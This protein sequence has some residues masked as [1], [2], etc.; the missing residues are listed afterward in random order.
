[1]EEKFYLDDFELSLKEH[2]DQFKM[3]PTKRVWH[4]IYNDLHPG[5]RWPS[6]MI[7]LL[8][9][10]STVFVGYINSHT[11]RKSADQ[12]LKAPV[13]RQGNMVKP[14]LNSQ[15]EQLSSKP[16]GQTKNN[17]DG[18]KRNNENAIK[19]TTASTVKKE[20]SFG[21]ETN[22]KS[23]SG[24][25][26][27]NKGIG[28]TDISFVGIESGENRQVQ[29]A[30][31]PAKYKN[32]Y[33]LD[34]KE[35][36]TGQKIIGTEN[37]EIQNTAVGITTIQISSFDSEA[38]IS[39]ILNTDE[40]IHNDIPALKGKSIKESEILSNNMADY[41]DAKNQLT[42]NENALIA[43]TRKRNGKISWVYYA[44]PFISSVSFKGQPLK[45]KSNSNLTPTTPLPQVTQKDIR[46]IHNTAFGFE[47]GV[48][49]NYSLTSNLQLT[50]GVHITRS[51]YNIISNLVH[52][53]LSTLILRDPS[54]GNTNSR[55]FVTHYGDGT[56]MSTVTLKNYS[57][58]T[59]L[60]VGLQ[61]KMWGNDKFQINLGANIEPS[62]VI[63]ADA[64]IL[65]SDGRN[66]VNVPD[67]LR[68]WNLS[69]NFAPFV[70]FR[71]DK[72]RWNIGPNIRYQWLSTYQKNY[73]V[74]E[75]LIDY[76]IRVGISK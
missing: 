16:V 40:K 61:Y 34:N 49:M 24:I 44:S 41:K 35:N 3:A 73:T 27:K 2:A 48:Q 69:S 76:G 13:S 59:S 54:T 6:V 17:I 51:G 42:G 46:M 29:T 56:G 43:T 15:I 47:T 7:S 57:Y 70:S 25:K 9:I 21:P 30:G 32:R 55:N 75:H 58:Q 28:Q 36:S 74:R 39:G 68:K 22:I 66:Y 14:E 4:G 53:T 5:R 62:Y 33:S 8:L 26:I 31:A 23:G 18:Q 11:D 72:F 37:S 71:S 38:K 50:A 64:Y 19:G 60:P 65:S 45:E 52:P 67:L 20:N 10:F 63:K 1:M 12:I